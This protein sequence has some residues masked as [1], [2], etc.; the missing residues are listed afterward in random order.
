MD[1]LPDIEGQHGRHYEAR[2]VYLTNGADVARDGALWAGRSFTVSTS[3]ADVPA[4]SN[5]YAILANP[6]GSGVDAILYNRIFSNDL[7]DTDPSLFYRAHGGPTATLANAV[8]V[9]NADIGQGPGA[10]TFRYEVGAVAMGG[11]E[12]TGELLPRG[13]PYSRPLVVRMRP[14]VSLG[15]SIQGIGGGVQSAVKLAMVFEWYEV[16]A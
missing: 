9:P 6:A 7:T 4:G 14:G 10:M 8:T 13:R 3:I 12:A 1:V 15:F 16:P 5:L 11:I 2:P